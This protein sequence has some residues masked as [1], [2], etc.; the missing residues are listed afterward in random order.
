MLDGFSKKHWVNENYEIDNNSVCNDITEVLA[1]VGD[2]DGVQTL[3]A[4][5]EAEVPNWHRNLG[6]WPMSIL[7]LTADC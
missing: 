6:T 4:S 7:D 2:F 1:H 3:R 5:E